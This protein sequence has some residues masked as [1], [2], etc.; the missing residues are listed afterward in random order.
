MVFFLFCEKNWIFWNFLIFSEILWCFWKFL[1]LL[2]ICD[3]VENLWFCWKFVIFENLWFSG[4]LLAKNRCFCS[5]YPNCL[6]HN[7]PWK[8]LFSK[9]LSINRY[10]VF[11]SKNLRKKIG[12]HRGLKKVRSRFIFFIHFFTFFYQF[13]GKK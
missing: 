3:F 5:F 6:A 11:S 7:L 1:K 9:I 10:R 13:S 2:K 4:L 8:S 12:G